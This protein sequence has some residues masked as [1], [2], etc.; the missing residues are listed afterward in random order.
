[1]DFRAFSKSITGFDPY[2]YQIAVAEKLLS[3]KNV[4]LSV[5]TGA[6]KT[7]ASVLP[8]L[9]AKENPNIHFPLKMIYSLPLR[10]L[11]NSIYQD[12]QSVLDNKSMSISKQTGEFSEDK[13]FENDMVFSTIDQ[14]LSNFLCFPLPLSKRQANINAGAMIGSYLV[15]D[16]FH[17]LE[18]ELS[19]A[20]TL[21]TIRQMRNLCRFCIMTA[22]LSKKFMDDLKKNLSSDD[23]EVE[24]IT[25][26]DYPND[27]PKI[28]SLIPP[29]YSSIKKTLEIAKSKLSAQ[30]I[31]AH[32][33]NRTI[34][35][36]NRVETAQRLYL[37]AKQL[38]K[39]ETELVCLHSRF[40]DTD[41][42]EKEARLK[43]L[44]GRGSIK[45]GILITTQVVEAGMDI[46]CEVLHSEI[47]PVNSLLQRAGRCARFGGEAGH[48][49]IYDIFEEVEEG[50]SS[51]DEALL[52]KRK[53]KKYLPYEAELCEKSL[54]H[55]SDYCHLDEKV[56]NELIEKV[57]GEKEEMIMTQLEN[58]EF[59]HDKIQNAWLSC[60]KNHYKKTIRDINN[61]EITIIS[62]DLKEEIIKS[63]FERQTVGM[64][65][66]SFVGWVK[67]MI[68]KI[69]ED[70][71]LIKELGENQVFANDEDEK[72]QLNPV[73]ID[74]IQPQV[75]VNAKYFG[76]SPDFGFNV[77][78]RDS[79]GNVS[80]PKIGSNKAK[81]HGL[82]EK[83]TFFQHNMGLM[84][85]F[86]KEFLPNM[87]FAFIELS[88]FLEED[89]LEEKDWINAI[90]LM[91]ILHDYGKLN[92]DWQNK[93]QDYQRLKYLCE[94]KP[95]IN[96]VLAHTDF[97][98]Y[99]SKH[100]EFAKQTG[101]FKRPP[102]AGVGAY[103]AQNIV[104]KL[105]SSV[106]LAN[107]ISTAI[108]RHHAPL[109]MEC[110]KFDILDTNY[111]AIEEL[112]K[113]YNFNN[114]KLA[115]KGI[116]INI[117]GV[118]NEEQ[119]LVYLFLVRI[120]RICDQKATE[121]LKNYFNG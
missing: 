106:A 45:N 117:E 114:I 75:Y 23:C 51:D 95:I 100:Q 65:K 96:E 103:V 76:Y 120:L 62:N 60:E 94:G 101:I 33:K 32:H 26:E 85:C 71:W 50:E 16:E 13:H 107:A 118:A 88:K 14:T 69:E 110:P 48:V 19:M 66:F 37:D 21:G 77:F 12:V 4:I 99:N 1:M 52:R 119:H 29:Q 54:T 58:G 92:T 5:P 28:K 111:V 49:I 31:I 41:R 59:N 61:V 64:F 121:N 81:T 20:T 46:S 112:L 113:K 9:Y 24:I 6:G 93:M 91:I 44:F 17:L 109:S 56:A 27:I 78:D 11:T 22:T 74:K 80:P 108:A 18:T 89:H 67:K 57:L 70:D 98:M 3:G 115:K 43:V 47:S 105:F 116:K 87:D 104:E 10:A 38:K 55:L 42:K 15:F 30:N 25:L 63:P 53:Y 82:L 102:H 40:F 35:I 90:R 68:D 97:D 86:E 79:L 84:Y 36:C 2:D 72:Y 39:D 34:V 7:W 83:D 73:N 8:F